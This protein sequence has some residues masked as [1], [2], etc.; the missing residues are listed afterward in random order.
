MPVFGEIFL[1]YYGC[2]RE[3]PED[4]TQ[5]DLSGAETRIGDRAKPFDEQPLRQIFYGSGAGVTI[6]PVG[7][8]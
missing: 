6:L 1:Y 5:A 7:I 2:V 8:D 4:A 3:C